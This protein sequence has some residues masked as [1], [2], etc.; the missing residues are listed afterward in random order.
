MSLTGLA[1]RRPSGARSAPTNH[2]RL[3][4][5]SRG[6][7]QCS[8][9]Q[10]GP[11]ASSV[12]VDARPSSPRTEYT[13]CDIVINATR[14]RSQPNPGSIPEKSMVLEPARV[15]S[16]I[17]PRYR[18]DSPWPPSRRGRTGL[19]THQILILDRALL[20]S[21]L[22]TAFSNPMSRERGRKA[23]KRS[24]TASIAQGDSRLPRMAHGSSRYMPIG[25]GFH[26]DDI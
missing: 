14:N 19:Q 22:P 18:F 8:R 6:R 9:Y 7:F 4:P 23:R 26:S 1:S 25:D 21:E 16:R 15:A 11:S 17:A 3:R 13:V 10:V 20:G 12:A 2:D 24:S 5:L